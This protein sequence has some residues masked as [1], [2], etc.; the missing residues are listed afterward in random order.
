[1]RN[2][3]F[4]SGWLIVAAAAMLLTVPW[5]C[6]AQATEVATLRLLPATLPKAS[7]KHPYRYQFEVEGGTAPARFAIVK[8][9][10]PAGM[11]LS[12]EG[13]LSGSPAV[14]GDYSFSVGV[15]DSS[16]PPQMASR[17]YLLHVVTP[18]LLTWV[19]QVEITG[20]RTDGVVA[21]SNSTEDD[22]DFTF[23]V[24]AVNEYGRAFAIGYQHFLLKSGADDLE[25]PFGDT[26]PRG[27]YVVHVDGVAEVPAK[28]RIYRARLQSKKLELTAGP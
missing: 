18:L 20:H 25:I 28:E 10:L 27:S 7:P 1:V 19:R 17:E 24:L 11:K 23:I 15:R 26:L 13:E 6:A 5:R 3:Q 4:S 8:G 12:P 9:V 22:F 2:S 16:R 14:L 21:A